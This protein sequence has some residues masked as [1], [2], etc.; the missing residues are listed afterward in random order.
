MKISLNWLKDYIDISIDHKEVASILTDIGLEVSGFE[1]FEPVKGGLSGVVTGKVLEA[2]KHPDADKLTVCKVDTGAGIKQ[3]VCGAPNVA[4]GQNV[5]VA[6][7]GSKLFFKDNEL[8][9]KKVKIRGVESCGMICAEDEIGLGESHEGIM[10][11]DMDTPIGIPA[12]EYFGLQNDIV[13]DIDLTPNRIDGASHYGVARDLAAYLSQAGKVS[14][15]KPLTEPFKPDT[16]GRRIDVVIENTEACPRYTGLTIT[17]VNIGESPDWLKFRLKAVGLKPINNI[18]DISNYVLHETGHPLHIFDADKIKGGK[19]VVRTLATGTRFRTLDEKERILDATD[20]MICNAEEG[21]C[22]AGVF[23]GIDSGVCPETK[24]IFIESAFFNPVW[25]RKT[26]KRHGLST[27]SSFRFE[28]GADPNFTVA[29]IKRAAV[30]I[31]QLAGGTISSDIVDVY[32]EPVKPKTV[33]LL[34]SNIDRL[35]GNE[36][37]KNDILHILKSLEIKIIAEKEIGLLLEIPTYRVD[38]TR[39]ADVIE[40]IL[41]IYGYNKVTTSTK[42]KST[43]QYG[44]KSDKEKITNKISNMLS[45]SGFNE[46]MSNSLTRFTYY[47]HSKSYKQANTVKIFNPLSQDLNCLRQTLLYGGLEAVGYNLNRK[48]TDLKFYEFGN[49]YYLPEKEHDAHPLARYDECE[50]LALFITGNKNAVNWNSPEVR[51]D[52]F[53]LKGYVENV[54][55]RM[56]LTPEIM[57]FTSFSDYNFCEAIRYEMDGNLMA[58]AGKLS[59][60][61]LSDFDIKTDVFYAD[62]RW[63]NLVKLMDDT[64]LKFSPIPKYPIARRDLALVI[65]TGVS[66]QNIRETALKTENILLK[67]IDLFDY[68][69]GPQVEKGKKS[70]ALAFYLLDENKT[71]TDTQIERIMN[72]LVTVFGKELGAKIR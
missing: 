7:E 19:V 32:P 59:N 6:L 70:Y 39:E 34:F 3:I 30:L 62:V 53:H 18:V 28:R 26:A 54:F 8:E 60:S 56:G 47:E 50:H 61:I 57:E 41:R 48:N 22:I 46:I 31:K 14:V 11:L 16:E 71:L 24:D 21:M 36:I 69:Q 23:G 2:F 10:V 29:A 63:Y 20:L 65:D 45:Y 42:V 1:V 17:G 72:K 4:A 12:A 37:S 51:T 66:F 52:F 9:I 5:I 27:D 64:K 68:Y 67:K 44:A 13:F 49:C 43:I 40:E 55:T 25:V 15:K 33:E 35:I 58:E 38:V